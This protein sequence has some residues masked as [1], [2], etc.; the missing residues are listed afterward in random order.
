MTASNVASAKSSEWVSPTWYSMRSETP[1][2][3]ERRRAASDEARANIYAGNVTLEFGALRD[4]AW[5]ETG[6]AAQVEQIMN[7]RE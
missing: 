1:S 3:W 4:R 7:G 2:S 5:R 6:A